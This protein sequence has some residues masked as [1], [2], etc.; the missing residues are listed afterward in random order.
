M[1]TAFTQDHSTVDLYKDNVNVSLSIN[2]LSRTRYRFMLFFI[3][4][5][6]SIALLVSRR[7]FQFFILQKQGKQY[8][9]DLLLQEQQ[10]FLM[11][12]QRQIEISLQKNYNI[13][14]T[15]SFNHTSYSA[16]VQD[17]SLTG[18]LPLLDGH[19]HPSTGS[20]LF[21]DDTDSDLQ[22]PL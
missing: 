8:Q 17:S 6:I 20:S 21:F 7:H 16:H 1:S 22:T 13:S 14:S 9:Q 12:Q 19:H 2:I 3:A 15:L 18:S 4:A 11:L 10:Q 5:N